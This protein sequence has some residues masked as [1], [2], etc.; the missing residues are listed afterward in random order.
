MAGL[1][2][3]VAQRTAAWSCAALL[4]T[5]A[6][7]CS[8]PQADTDTSEF[9]IP[10]PGAAAATCVDA[11]AVC[12]PA[13]CCPLL[14]CK[15]GAEQQSVCRGPEPEPQL[16]WGIHPRASDALRLA[17]VTKSRIVQTIGDA[18]NSGGTHLEDGTFEDSVYSAA[19]DIS[20]DKLSDTQIRTLLDRLG[21]L[22][23]AAWYRQP[24]HDDWPAQDSAH[25][26]AVYAGCEM[27]P[28][29]QVQVA[30]WLRGKNGLLSDSTY[31]FYTWNPTAQQA[32]QETFAASDSGAQN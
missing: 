3:R 27:K 13:G 5:A 29:L 12:S 7:S 31:A 6:V 32:V 14:L 8:A 24:G 28:L 17:G 23:F 25:I 1:Q 2:L 22:G 21:R 30:A 4:A 15:A 16:D 19:T 20:A 26:H 9:A 18:T 10:E 11:D